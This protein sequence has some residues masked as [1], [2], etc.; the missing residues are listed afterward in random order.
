MENKE[1]VD[2]GFVKSAKRAL[3]YIDEFLEDTKIKNTDKEAIIIILFSI[4]QILEEGWKE[5]D[6]LATIAEEEWWRILEIADKTIYLH[7]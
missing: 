1:E 7:W 3:S 2:T 5:G 6:K 4:A